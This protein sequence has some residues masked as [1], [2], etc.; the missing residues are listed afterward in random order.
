MIGED[1]EKIAGVLKKKKSYQEEWP[2]RSG[3]I[4][5]R[6]AQEV[7]TGILEEICYLHLLWVGFG[8]FVLASPAF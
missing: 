4:P 5:E 2:R 7:R 1:C 3:R 8:H 6:T